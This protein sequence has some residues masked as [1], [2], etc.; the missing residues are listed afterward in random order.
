MTQQSK[1]PWPAW[2]LVLDLLGSFLIGIGVFALVA[3]D[4]LPLADSINLRSLAVPLII[5][6]ALLFAP[7]ILMTV[8]RIRG[9]R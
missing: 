2:V 5:I 6:G 8:A 4:P 9:S 1:L 3:D 7:L